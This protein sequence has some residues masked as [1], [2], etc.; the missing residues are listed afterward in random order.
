MREAAKRGA[1]QVGLEARE[2]LRI[3]AGI[4]KYGADMD[5][6]VIALEAGL[7]PTHISLKKG[8]Y[9]GQEI[10]ARIDSR[11]HTNRALTGLVFPVGS[12]P[13]SGEEIMSAPSPE[14]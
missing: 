9:V 13:L 4:P 14:N 11:G 1:L 8:C 2:L 3:E 6:T 5:S 7:G 12:D 10:I